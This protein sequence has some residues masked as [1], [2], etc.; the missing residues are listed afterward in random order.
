[1]EVRGMRRHL[2]INGLNTKDKIIECLKQV[3]AFFTTILAIE[4]EI[5]DCFKLGVGPYKPVV[6]LVDSIISR[7]T[8]FQ[9]M[10]AYKKDCDEKEAE[11]IVYISDYVPAATKER[12]RKER[13]VYRSNEADQSTKEQMTMERGT[14]KV[15]GVPC[16]STITPPDATKI[17]S[18]TESQLDIIYA[19]KFNRGS[20]C[21]RDNSSFTGFSLPVNSH[22]A[23]DYAYMKLRLMFPQAAHILCGYSIPDMPRYSHEE[24]CDDGEVGGGRQLMNI[25]K[26]NR[27]TNIALFVVREQWGDKIGPERFSL[28]TQAIVNAMK[29]KPYNVFTNSTQML[30]PDNIEEKIPQIQ[31]RRA[32]EPRMTRNPR[33]RP[34]V[35]RQSSSRGILNDSN[36]RRR[37]NSSSETDT[38]FQFTNPTT[39]GWKADINSEFAN[40]INVNERSDL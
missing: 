13:E 2:V 26:K 27:L 7:A 22:Q 1:M 9:A 21:S 15:K 34:S 17:L 31:Q 35:R 20:T 11:Q 28:M 32:L 29:A 6:I 19:I 24:Y 30:A 5:I 14:L 36:K 12:K 10:D 3:K 38:I 40:S 8:I 18:Y 37:Q 33:G 25:I 4:I 39:L 23:I 16:K